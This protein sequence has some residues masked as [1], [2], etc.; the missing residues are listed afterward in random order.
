MKHKPYLLKN[1]ARDLNIDL[2]HLTPK[3]YAILKNHVEGEE[4]KKLEE[5]VYS[6]I[7]REVY[8]ED[9]G[10]VEITFDGQKR[11][12]HKD[13]RWGNNR[14]NQEHSKLFWERVEKFLSDAE[15]VEQENFMDVMYGREVLKQETKLEYYIAGFFSG[16]HSGYLLTLDSLTD[17]LANNKDLIS[18]EAREKLFDFVKNHH[19]GIQMPH[20]SN[21]NKS[22]EV[23]RKSKTGMFQ[24]W[25]V[26]STTLGKTHQELKKCLKFQ[27]T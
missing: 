9:Y 20:P 22:L 7:G 8:G 15:K 25:D 23:L 10:Y 19:K 27:C 3:H 2:E 16:I 26:N 12:F 17:F 13:N 1:A 18:D 5:C 24:D 4:F 14:Y 6:R 11:L 21:T